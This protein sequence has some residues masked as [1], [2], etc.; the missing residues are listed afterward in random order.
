MNKPNFILDFDNVLFY[1]WFAH[2]SYLN[3]IYGINTV[4]EDY[5]DS[6]P[7]TSLVNKYL[8]GRNITSPEFYV[9]F[10]EDFSKSL[11]RHKDVFPLKGMPEVLS[12]IKKKYKLWVVTARTENSLHIMKYLIDKYIP[13]CLEEIYF[14]R[15]YIGNGNYERSPKINLIEKIPEKKVAFIDDCLREVTATKDILPSYLFDQHNFYR[16][17]DKGVKVVKNWEE[18]G[19]LFL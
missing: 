2:L 8:P 5:L 7:L 11:E 19:N 12:E 16:D 17:V 18:I 14:V 6:P 10:E 1:T 9:L 4:L 15:K 3:E 13:N